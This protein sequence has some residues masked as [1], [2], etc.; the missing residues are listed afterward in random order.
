[1]RIYLIAFLIVVWIVWWK[2]KNSPDEAAR[3]RLVRNSIL[4]GLIGVI[5]LLA[6]MGRIHWLGAAFAAL[7]PILKF[8]FAALL[9]FFPALAKIYASRSSNSQAPVTKSAMGLSEAR[10]IL[11]VNQGASEEEIQMAYKRHM[12]KVH[13]DK[14][15]N[16]YFATKLNEA[17]DLLLKDIG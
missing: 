1:M 17:R 15:G 12:Q 4:Y 10:D 7:F 9:R 5:F 11:G 6:A 14:G 2:W 3:R 8:V 16:E 13:P